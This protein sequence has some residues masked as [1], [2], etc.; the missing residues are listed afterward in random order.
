MRQIKLATDVTSDTIID[1]YDMTDLCRKGENIV[2]VHLHFPTIKCY[3]I[4]YYP[5]SF[6]GAKDAM[7]GEPKEVLVKVIYHMQPENA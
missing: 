5:E 4:K 2:E 7:N 3:D 1:I 6:S